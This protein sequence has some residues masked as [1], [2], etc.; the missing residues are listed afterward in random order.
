MTRTPRRTVAGPVGPITPIMPG[1][2][3]QGLMKQIGTGS[4]VIVEVDGNT[5]Y[6]PTTTHGP[7]GSSKMTVTLA[8]GRRF[9]NA[10]LVGADPKTDL[11]VVKIEADNLKPA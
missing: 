4:G 2:P 8:D 9:D 11:A 10:K 3:D 5:G 7:G 1:L 6:I